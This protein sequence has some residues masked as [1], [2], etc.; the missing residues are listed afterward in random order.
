VVLVSGESAA[1]LLRLSL[2]SGA[3]AVVSKANLKDLV[4]AV[5]RALRRRDSQSSG[6]GYG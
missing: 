6:S 5:R 3:N 1:E 2:E 4:P